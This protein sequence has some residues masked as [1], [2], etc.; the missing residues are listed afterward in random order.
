[1]QL[2]S[3]YRLNKER[4]A[5]GEDLQVPELLCRHAD[6][7]AHK[8]FPL[9][10]KIVAKLSPPLQWRGGMVSELYKGKGCSSACSNYRDIMLADISSKNLGKLLRHKIIPGARAF[11]VH[12]QF[13]GGM[14]SGDSSKAHIYLRMLM[15][16]GSLL[17]MSMSVVFL[18]I[19]AAFAT[20]MRRIVF[21]IE[22]GDEKWLYSLHAAGFTEVEVKD[23]YS[24]VCRS[25]S[26][27]F[28][29][30][31]ITFA[32][33]ACMYQYTW[34]STEG[35]NTNLHTENGSAAGTPLADL[36]YVI[37]ISKVMLRLRSV[38]EAEGLVQHVQ[39][40]GVVLL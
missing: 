37:S 31:T 7:V 8:L 9:R 24:E 34:A 26:S 40:M 4:K 18:D 1:M 19:V 20:M 17:N 15:E 25:L 22:G 14:N 35:L 38:L 33:A 39:P 3:D 12:T 27:L 13:G 36:M 10:I 28:D 30:N 6:I 29:C 16:V 21:D 32:L 2:T 23:I 5:C 11:I